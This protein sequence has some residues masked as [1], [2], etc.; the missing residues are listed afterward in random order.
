M[1]HRSKTANL[2]LSGGGIKGIAYIGMFEEAEKRG[3]SFANISGVSAG[4][5]VGSLKGAGYNA[6]EL[7]KILH[8]IDFGKITDK[9]IERR[10]PAVAKFR[11]YY[12][13]KR[14]GNDD[15]FQSFLNLGYV[16]LTN[17]LYS[18]SGV[19]LS[20]S[21]NN[22]LKNVIEYCKDGCLCDGDYL[23]ELVYKELLKKGV[24]TFDDLRDKMTHKSDYKYYRVR[25]TAVDA[26]RAKIIVLPDDIGYYGI[27]PDKLEVAKAV[28]M[29][30]SIPF[31]FK[32]IELYKKVG[33]SS[34]K[35]SI[36]DGG[37]LD[38]FPLWLAGTS[39][40]HPLVG[41]RLD[42]GEKKKTF[43]A[44]NSLNI[45]KGLVSAVHDF[46]IPKTNIKSCI[47]IK[48]NTSKVSFLDFDLGDDEKEELISAGRL[49]AA[50]PLDEFIG[51][52]KGGENYMFNFIR[53]LI[54]GIF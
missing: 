17:S 16:S 15:A 39:Q 23:E 10:V 9:D 50:G 41:A 24:K 52:G 13:N 37:V 36:V 11:D 32:P 1:N 30:T 4:A 8:E 45:I 26:S 7:K 48:I 54:R 33:N 31:I 18:H 53:K 6:S 44:S 2:V 43:S 38:N 5:L 22:F 19:Q 42:G 49:A 3:I 21:R 34:N 47:V 12:Y 28:R 29:S 46:G 40:Y 35:Y 14:P 51:M 25:M 27:N 20:R